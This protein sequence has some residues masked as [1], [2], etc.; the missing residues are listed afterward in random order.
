MAEA[1]IK[2]GIWISAQLRL[3]DQAFLPAVV[4]RKGDPDAGAILIKLDRLDGTAEVLSQ[5]RTIDGELAWMRATGE[6]PAPDAEAEAYIAKQLKFDPDIWVLE[7][8]DPQG[9]YEI[10]GRVV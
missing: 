5:V 6:G 3:C 8:E 7:I 4:R 1:R 10:D 9:R 2:A